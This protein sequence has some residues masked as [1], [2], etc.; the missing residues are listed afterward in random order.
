MPENNSKSPYRSALDAAELQRLA[1]A[2]PVEFR[3]QGALHPTVFSSEARVERLVTLAEFDFSLGQHRLAR[4]LVIGTIRE[5]D[6]EP[7]AYAA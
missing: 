5:T 6:G 4:T 3:R 7:R 1:A 2:L